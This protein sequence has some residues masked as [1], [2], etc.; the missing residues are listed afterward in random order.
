MFPWSKKH[1]KFSQKSC[2]I[3]S[4]S[5]LSVFATGYV[6]FESES[7]FYTAVVTGLTPRTPVDSR[8]LPWTPRP[9]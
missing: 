2:A 6:E 4:G 9:N 3:M 5:P 1:G 8:G 7:G